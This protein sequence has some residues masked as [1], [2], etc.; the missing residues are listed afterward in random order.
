[1][2]VT[3]V[4]MAGGTGE[5]LWPLVRRNRPK[6]CLSPDGRRSL[7]RGTLERLGGVA[8][9]PRWL[10][11][12]TPDQARAVRREVPP[13][14]RRRVVVEPAIRNTAGCLA[15]AVLLAA[16]RHPH[17]VLVALPADHWVRDEAAF[18]RALRTAIATA[19]RVHAPV[20]LGIRPTHPH[21]GFG[22]VRAAAQVGRGPGPRVFRVAQFIEKPSA[23]RAAAL[24]RR[25]RAFWN[26]GIFVARVEVF[27]HAFQ[28]HLPGHLRRLA[29]AV[30]SGRGLAAAYRALPSVSFD[31]GVMDHLRERYVVE[32]RFGWADLGSWDTWARL[33][34][35]R[36]RFLA[37]DAHN[38]TVVSQEPHLIAAVGV[39][40]LVV[41]QTRAATLLCHPARTQAVRDIVRRLER[42]G[43]RAFL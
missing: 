28:A 16:R 18:R 13:A 38:V 29:P 36:A 41:V 12:T 32:G 3:F 4:I 43:A 1:M 10:V 35:G 15:L 30:R 8:P 33:G 37:L 17:D 23:S 5:R 22:Y 7:L 26:A 19:R 27:L 39:R 34:H 11:V 25:G 21:P 42:N 2:A 9:R 20:L 14:W 6:V 24:V 31:Y 40:D